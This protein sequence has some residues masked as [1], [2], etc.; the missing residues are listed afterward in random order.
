MI[1]RTENGKTVTQNWNHFAA[2][3]FSSGGTEVAV[4]EK[5]SRVTIEAAGKP[6]W[7]AK[8][9]NQLGSVGREPGQ[10]IAEAVGEAN[11]FDIGYLKRVTLPQ[12]VLKPETTTGLGQSKWALGGVKDGK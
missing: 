7:E 3:P 4:T 11:V 6:A 1:V 5:F 9:L 12:Y 8:T 10:T 2:G